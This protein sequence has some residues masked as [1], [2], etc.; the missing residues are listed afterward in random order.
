[1]EHQIPQA[2]PPT[3]KTRPQGWGAEAR[4][5]E[6]PLIGIDQQTGQFHEALAVFDRLYIR[7][8]GHHPLD[9]RK[10]A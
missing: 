4:A 2:E 5:D 7:R 1:M 3:R 6:S 8:H 10:E 9:S